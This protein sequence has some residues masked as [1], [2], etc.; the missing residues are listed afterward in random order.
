MSATTHVITVSQ[1][2]RI[3]V[4]AKD[5]VVLPAV[6]QQSCCLWFGRKIY[7]AVPRCLAESIM[8]CF[9]HCCSIEESIALEQAISAKWDAIPLS[10][11]NIIYSYSD[12]ESII[13]AYIT[14]LYSSFSVDPQKVSLLQFFQRNINCLD[15]HGINLHTDELGDEIFMLWPCGKIKKILELCP[16][17]KRLKLSKCGIGALDAEECTNN[18]FQELVKG[19]VNLEHL[20]LSYNEIAGTSLHLLSNLRHLKTLNLIGCTNVTD[21]EKNELLKLHV[22]RQLAVLEDKKELLRGA[23]K[24][25]VTKQHAP[26]IM[27]TIIDKKKQLKELDNLQSKF[28][29]LSL[30]STID[31][32]TGQAPHDPRSKIDSSEVKGFDEE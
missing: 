25:S 21:A 6:K 24:Q 14:T 27:L 16:D 28:E 5:P 19:C 17:V 29:A 31:P 22:E 8:R 3:D 2:K 26:P 18:C 32:P 7:E 1:P 20:D 13:V 23:Q 9:S 4:A 12:I 30:E 10:V 11:Q 15:F